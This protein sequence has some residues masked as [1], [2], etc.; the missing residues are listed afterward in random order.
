MKTIPGIIAASSLNHGWIVRAHIAALIEKESARKRQHGLRQISQYSTQARLQ[1]VISGR[2]VGLAALP[3]H[4][5]A[6][7]E[8]YPI[9]YSCS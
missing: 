1:I 8:L 7:G 9:G 2:N 6:E 5:A 3:D 4:A